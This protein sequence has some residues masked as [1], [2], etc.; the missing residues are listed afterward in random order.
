VAVEVEV[1]R[2]RAGVMP[3]HSTSLTSHRPNGR[4]AS[5]CASSAS[6][7]LSSGE[8]GCHGG[9][10]VAF[11]HAP[12]GEAV[13]A[14]RAFGEGGGDGEDGELVGVPTRRLSARRVP[15]RPSAARRARR[16]AVRWTPRCT[17]HRRPAATPPG[18]ASGTSRQR[19]S[20]SRR[21]GQA[22]GQAATPAGSTR[23]NRD[24]ERVNARWRACFQHERRDIKKP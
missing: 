4:G 11:L 19:R 23:G 8:A 24:R 9:E 15:L 6:C 18:R 7:R 17:A 16:R 1:A 10:A 21:S 5:A 14:R 2:R 13:H 12:F 20:G 3:P 22:R